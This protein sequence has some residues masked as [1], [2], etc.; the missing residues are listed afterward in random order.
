MFGL[1]FFK[2]FYFGLHWVLI[3]VQAFCS[4]GKQGLL[5]A[6]VCGLLIAVAS[7]VME[8]GL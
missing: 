5:C 4:Y 7:L 3:V 2:N 6:V 1:F 8:N